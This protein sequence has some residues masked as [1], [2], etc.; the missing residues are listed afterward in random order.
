[1]AYASRKRSGNTFDPRSLKLD[2]ASN[3]DDWREA[4]EPARDVKK[5]V[6]VLGL[7]ALSWVATYIGMLELIQAN[8]G[9]LPFTHKV[10][11]GF[12]VAML[13]V[14]IIW[15]LDQ[16]FKPHAASIKLAY[17]AGYLFLTTISVGFGFG[18]YWKVL[19][20]R[21]EASRSAE[22]AVSQVQSSLN[23]AS[24]RLAQ[25]QSTLAQLSDV[26]EKKSELERTKGT[27]CPNSRPGDGPRRKMRAADAAKFSFAAE[28]V[29]G[30]VG[31]IKQDI[32]ALDGDLAKIVKKDPSIV[33][34]KSGT[35]NAFMRSLGRKLDMTV[36][37][38]NAFR[39]DPQLKQLRSDLAARADKTVFQVAGGRSFTC[40]DPQL[41]QALRGAVRA[42]DQLPVL[43][44]PKIAVVEG[45]EATIEAFRRLTATLQGALT[46]KLP[47]S[48]DE[49][50][51]LQQ[52]AIRQAVSKSDRAKLATETA[53]L[54]S[55]DYVPLAIALFVD[56][57]LLLVSMGRSTNRIE[58]LVPKMRAAE[59]GPVIEILSRFKDIHRDPEVR[60][61]FEV[62]RHV[63]FDQNGDYYVAVPL[64]A[65]YGGTPHGMTAGRYGTEQAQELQHEAHLLANLFTS[66]EKERIFRRVYNPVLLNT[67]A[68][69]KRLARQ[70]SK[71]AG[72]E[73]FRVYKFRDGAWS[74][75]I[76]GAVMGAARRAEA[77][78]R[79]T[80]LER[81]LFRAQTGE[82]D[83]GLSP[84]QQGDA[85][86]RIADAVSTSVRD[87]TETAAFDLVNSEKHG[88]V[89]GGDTGAASVSREDAPDAATSD[90]IGSDVLASGATASDVIN[91]NTPSAGVT[92]Q[93]QPRRTRPRQQA[94]VT[95]AHEAKYGPY[96]V[97]VSDDDD[98]DASEM[99]ESDSWQDVAEADVSLTTPGASGEHSDQVSHDLM[100]DHATDQPF[101]EDDQDAEEAEV[102]AL[103]SL[104]AEDATAVGEIVHGDESIEDSSVA[105]AVIE[106]AAPTVASASVN[107]SLTSNQH[108]DVVLTRDTATFSVPVTEATLPNGVAGLMRKAL[109]AADAELNHVK[110]VKSEALIGDQPGVPQLESGHLPALVHDPADAQNNVSS[111]D[112]TGKDD[113]DLS[114]LASRFA[115]Q[116][117]F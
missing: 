78:R 93:Q 58:N 68:I 99:S 12:S 84:S 47:P 109:V 114:R 10:V 23:G 111:Q 38:F 96:A 59:R 100:L 106:V 3:D 88:A 83:L 43:D 60:D 52:K 53:G 91:G 80:E 67:R 117:E 103:P 71:F 25:L 46:F 45:S 11:I 113:E 104:E 94:T 36:A 50:R 30:R 54:S 24:I 34:T 15:L 26:S 115:A 56:L 16:L 48:A 97:H 33:D 72:C 89:S 55:R 98:I 75:I 17:V 42:F 86:S 32:K 2:F 66:F 19:E 6:L 31:A 76:L 112:V 4:P 8:L 1:M 77:K 87:R 27:S 107:A 5:F 62:F 81:E 101:T 51:A 79:R 9:T 70:G 105:P 37:G 73:A 29:A 39:T 82:P 35:R 85:A 61:N 108:V 95:P 57:C 110:P 22:S 41:Q 40:P 18:F 102:I 64:D 44:K 90:S 28:F 49:M 14:M 69:Q 65:P 7:G 74:D 21:T 116:T 63:V 13:M 20:S 92:A